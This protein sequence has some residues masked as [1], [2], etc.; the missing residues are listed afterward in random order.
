MGTVL[1]SNKGQIVIPKELR[2][3][4]GIEPKRRVEVTEIGNHIGIIPLPK[5]SLKEARGMLKWG[6]KAT[7][8]LLKE[9]AK[10]KKL[11]EE[12]AKRWLKK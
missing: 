9:R 6:E 7:Q 2:E 5:D 11:D 8:I 1:V 4:Y 3:K 12:R 10:D